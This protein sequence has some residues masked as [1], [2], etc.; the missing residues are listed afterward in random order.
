[1]E[2]RTEKGW[3]ISK[4]VELNLMGNIQMEKGMEE[5]WSMMKIIIIEL[6]S[7]VNI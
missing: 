3:N 4:M 5:E 1:M 2:Q 6:F 7:K